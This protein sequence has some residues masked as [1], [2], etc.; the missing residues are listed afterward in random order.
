MNCNF[1]AFVNS[2]SLLAVVVVIFEELT[3]CKELYN[4]K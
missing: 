4:N 3:F 2:W 1:F